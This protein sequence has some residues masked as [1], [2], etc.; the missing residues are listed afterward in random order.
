MKNI[1]PNGKCWYQHFPVLPQGTRFPR[2]VLWNEGLIFN[3]LWTCLHSFNC[4]NPLLHRY[5][6]WCINNRQILKTLWEKEKLLVMSN[7]SFSHNV[8]LLYLFLHL[9]TFDIISL[10]AAELEE[11]KIGIS[12]KG[13][14]FWTSTV[15]GAREIAGQ[16]LTFQ[17]MCCQIWELMIIIQ[18]KVWEMQFLLFFMHRRL[19]L[20]FV[21]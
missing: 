6:F 10:F 12:P 19:T 18:T 4:L 9:S 3:H 14:M 8:F 15:L 5:S 2:V 17:N 16:D 11:C 7:F 13:L 21:D 20:W 1:V